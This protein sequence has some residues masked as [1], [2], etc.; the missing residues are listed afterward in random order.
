MRVQEID[1]CFNDIVKQGYVYFHSKHLWIYRRFWLILRTASTKG[2]RRLEQF[3]KEQAANCQCKHKEKGLTELRTVSRPL[4]EK[5]KNTI[6]LT[7][8]D[9]SQKDF[10]CDSEQFH[11]FLK[12]ST[13]M[14]FYREC[15]LQFSCD[16]LWL[17][18]S[19]N[20]CRKI[21]SWPLK[22][23]RRYGRSQTWFTF[24]AG[25]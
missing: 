9:D 20:P 1:L 25:R 14:E 2:P 10:A 19:R 12:P 7:S 15:I 3:S 17:W 23:L 11:V 16:A 13:S 18:D 22:A 4:Q 24:E 8:K 5:K 6:I 21:T